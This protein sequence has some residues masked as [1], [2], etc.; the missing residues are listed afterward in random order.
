[1][2][3][4]A[5]L[6]LAPA[7]GQAGG[8]A[9]DGAPGFAD[10][11]ARHGSG[12][13]APARNVETDAASTVADE[14]LPSS[15]RPG[16]QAVPETGDSDG[17]ARSWSAQ[18]LHKVLATLLGD[19][20]SS[21]AEPS[22]DSVGDTLA[23][24][25]VRLSAEEATP[26]E[27]EPKDEDEAATV[28]ETDR[29]EAEAQMAA[30]APG[31]ILPMQPR[32]QRAGQIAASRP[33]EHPAAART[34]PAEPSAE[35]P[36]DGK[37]GTQTGHDRRGEAA[38]QA[39]KGAKLAPEIG[40]MKVRVIGETV[41]PAPGVSQNQRTITELVATIAT[42][43]DWKSALERATAARMEA[44]NTPVGPVRDL[45]IQLNP[46]E[47][48]SVE[49]R[50]RIVGEQLSVEIRV[51]NGDALR[52]LSS[53]RDAI[54]TALRG[55]GFAVDDVSIQQQSPTSGQSQTGAGNR[56][57]DASGEQSQGTG[58][59]RQDDGE[60][61]ANRRGD[62]EQ[63]GQ[64]GDANTPATRAAGGGLYI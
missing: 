64:N 21:D 11:V 24:T 62:G 38:A 28:S 51:E 42:D 37:D 3:D 17:E 47:L 44:A 16:S 29:H 32:E 48:G 14:A 52:R 40:D 23:E 58:R 36:G 4:L 55:L 54:L 12:K 31:L 43:G 30:V 50:L 33:A 57:G 41:M 53:E 1:M 9:R 34:S 27:D 39:E 61:A 59:N 46:A 6:P 56:Q 18:G 45:R 49:A 19:R 15:D 20:G 25:V 2:I 5:T 22:P 13:A 10:L 26:A 7:G 8:G 35:E 60:A 63:G